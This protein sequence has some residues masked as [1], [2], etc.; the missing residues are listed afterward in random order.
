MLTQTGNTGHG[1]RLMKHRCRVANVVLGTTGSKRVR[2]RSLPRKLETVFERGRKE[3]E[4]LGCPFTEAAGGAGEEPVYHTVPCPGTQLTP[5]HLRGARVPCNNSRVREPC[6]PLT[7]ACLLQLMVWVGETRSESLHPPGC[8]FP[9]L[10]SL[11]LRSDS[12][13][14]PQSPFP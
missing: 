7:I 10:P 3:G 13:A 14:G 2:S 8:W 5:Q 11:W 9:K 6:V 4:G 1:T 12:R